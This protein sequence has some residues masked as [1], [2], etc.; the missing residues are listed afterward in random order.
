M[1]YSV[2]TSYYLLL[3][4]SR[5]QEGEGE[6][7]HSPWHRYSFRWV[8]AVSNSC[9]REGT[10]RLQWPCKFLGLRNQRRER[11]HEPPSLRRCL[12]PL[13]SPVGSSKT[14]RKWCHREWEWWTGKQESVSTTQIFRVLWCDT[15]ISFFFFLWFFTFRSLF[16]DTVMI[17]AHI[18]HLWDT[19]GALLQVQLHVILW[20][21]G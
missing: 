20:Q 3:R 5:A 4:K 17:V 15:E 8:S 12:A 18:W 6:G 11:K 14:E 16:Q 19:C 21:W 1:I 10:W 2:F 7:P 13:A 9:H